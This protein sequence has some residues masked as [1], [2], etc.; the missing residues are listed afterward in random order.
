[1]DQ[2]TPRKSVL[3]IAIMIAFA[4]FLVLSLAYFLYRAL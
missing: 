2:A 3:V 4:W 1:M